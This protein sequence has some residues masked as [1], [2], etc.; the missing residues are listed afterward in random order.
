MKTLRLEPLSLASVEITAASSLIN[1]NGR[2][3]LCSDDSYEI[4]ELGPSSSAGPGQ[5]LKHKWRGSP[6]LSIEPVDLK[7]VKPDFESMLKLDEHNI[8]VLPSGSRPNRTKAMVFNISTG[9]FSLRDLSEFFAHLG[10]RV[11]KVNIEGALKTPGKIILMN[12]GV[13]SH[14]SSMICVDDKTWK[15]Y[16]IMDIDF[17]RVDGIALHGSELCLWDDNLYA[18]LVAEDADNSYDD[19]QILGSALVKMSVDDFQV[20]DQWQFDGGT[21]MEGLCRFHN[22]RWLVVTDPDGKG[23]SEFYSFS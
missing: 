23:Q 7:K 10:D 1:V 11:A 8:L 19:G 15:I 16:M 14:P 2:I 21:K 6:L 9:E 20:N 5:W 12:R 17:G 3:F 22:E 4:Q 18:L 13:K